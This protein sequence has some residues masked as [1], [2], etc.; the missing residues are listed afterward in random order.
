MS[1]ERNA[2]VDVLHQII[3][4]KFPDRV[5]KFN[6]GE[7]EGGRNDNEI[8]SEYEGCR[9]VVMSISDRGK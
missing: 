4:S 6:G 1:V 3:W 5:V 7:Y 8:D 2:W 9:N